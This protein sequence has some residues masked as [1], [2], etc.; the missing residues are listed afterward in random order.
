MV[1]DTCKVWECGSEEEWLEAR[2]DY[3]TASEIACVCGIDPFKSPLRL[4]HEKRG[5]IEPQD[6]SGNA[7]VQAGKA[8][9]GTILTMYERE[10]GRKVDRCEPFRLHVNSDF[11]DIAATPD[12]FD[13]R[14]DIRQEG[15]VDAKNIGLRMAHHWDDGSPETYRLQL[16]MQMLVTGASQGSLAVLIGGQ[17]FRYFDHERSDRLCGIIVERAAD[18]MDRVRTGREPDVDDSRDCES[19]LRELFPEDNREG[20]ELPPEAFELYEDWDVLSAKAAAIEAELRRIK[21]RFTRWMEGATHGYLPNGQLACT[22]KTVN[23]KAYKV[24]ASSSRQLR[25]KAE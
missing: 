14:S 12:G 18:F 7:A 13:W 4:Y 9:E 21:S 17:D 15:L 25:R 3:V 20:V 5:D 19:L 22:L 23:K 1:A 10:S 8:L 6:L 16:E 24:A 2:R 11:P